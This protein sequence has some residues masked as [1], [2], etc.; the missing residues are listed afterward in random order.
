MITSR[1]TIIINLL[2][3]IMSLFFFKFLLLPFLHSSI[4]TASLCVRVVELIRRISANK[5][6][7]IIHIEDWSCVSLYINELS[8]SLLHIYE[9]EYEH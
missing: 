8:Y 2:F 1:S 9:N 6:F 3:E 4:Y 7:Y 5:A